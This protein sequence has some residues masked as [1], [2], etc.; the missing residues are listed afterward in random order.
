VLVV[1]RL[2]NNSNDSMTALSLFARLGALAAL[3][4]GV[5]VGWGW[6]FL[7]KTRTGAA[8]GRAAVWGPAAPL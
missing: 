2:N 4:G 8:A 1:K 7:F 3:A 6:S 5:W